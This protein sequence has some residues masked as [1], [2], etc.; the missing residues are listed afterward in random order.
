[1]R[2]TGWVQDKPFFNAK[3]KAVIA[4]AEVMTRNTAQRD[5]TVWEELKRHCTDVEI[6]GVHGLRHV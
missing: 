4:W 2:C 6:R 3:E 1:M 5:E